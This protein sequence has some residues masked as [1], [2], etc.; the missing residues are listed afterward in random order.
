MGRLKQKFGFTMVETMTAI[1]IATVIILSVMAATVFSLKFNTLEKT[2]TLA[3][4]AARNIM[5]QQVRTVKFETLVAKYNSTSTTCATYNTCPNGAQ[6]LG[7]GKTITL[8]SKKNNINNLT[9]SSLKNDLDRLNRAK[10]ELNIKILSAT[11][12]DVKIRILWD[13]NPDETVGSGTRSLELSTI[14]SNGDLNLKRSA[15][16]AVPS[17]AGGKPVLCDGTNSTTVCAVGTTCCTTGTINGVTCSVG[18]CITNTQKACQC[19]SILSNPSVGTITCALGINN[20]CPVVT[21]SLVPLN[22]FNWTCDTGDGV[23]KELTGC[24]TDST[25]GTGKACVSGFC[26]PT[27]TSTSCGQGYTCDTN[28]GKCFENLKCTTDSNCTTEKIC[29][30]GYCVLGCSTANPCP[31]GSSCNTTTKLCQ[32]T[33]YTCSPACK[34]KNGNCNPGDCEVCIPGVTAVCQDACIQSGSR[35]QG[36]ACNDFSQCASGTCKGGSL[37]PLKA[38]N[39]T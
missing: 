37:V 39:C 22:V 12:L 14:V 25:C 4:D 33:K 3:Q 23:C 6:A 29:S 18:S 9:T 5:S 7:D 16:L 28:I 35:P 26:Q 15:V 1:A 13:L 11:Q 36:C 8:Y 32:P 20:N 2:R 17:P 31:S 21:L 10:C 34:T 19:P 38:G 24:T 27:C 30:G